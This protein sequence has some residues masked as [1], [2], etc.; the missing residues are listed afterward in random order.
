MEH[1]VFGIY[2]LALVA[3]AASIMETFMIWQRY[4][5]AVIRLYGLFLCALSLI[6]LGFMV[7]LYARNVS[8]SVAASVGIVVLI[9][10]GAGGCLYIFIAPSF[11]NSLAGLSLPLWQR[12]LFSIIDALVVI[13]ALADIAN[14]RWGFLVIGLAGVLYSMI[15]YGVV[16]IA[17]HLR[18]IG[19]RTLR[20]ALGIFLGLTILFFPLMIVDVSMSMSPGPSVFQFMNNLAQPVYFLVLNGLTILFGLRYMNRP[21]FQE[22]GKLSAYFLSAFHVTDREAEIIDLLLGGATTGK[23]AEVLFISPK[24][25]EN[26]VYNIYQKLHVRNRVQMF[27]LIRTNALE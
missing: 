25:A 3:G 20:L 8:G 16:F 4:R 2:L 18:S 23:I 1:L 11:F 26:H 19:E 9:L 15:L 24:T 10:Q 17:I 13:A 27:Q 22:Q 5:R 14:P 21:S 7:D 6:L 12:I